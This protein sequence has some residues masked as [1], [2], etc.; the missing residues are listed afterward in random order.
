[1]HIVNICNIGS[2]INRG[3]LPAI[4]NLSKLLIILNGSNGRVIFICNSCIYSPIISKCSNGRAIFIGNTLIKCSVIIVESI[5]LP[6]IFK[7]ICYIALIVNLVNR[8]VLVIGNRG[9]CAVILVSNCAN[10]CICLV[11]D[12]C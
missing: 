9:Y 2:V 12:F 3:N 4:I 7:G 5:H 10:I 1:M 8:G 6:L 11:D